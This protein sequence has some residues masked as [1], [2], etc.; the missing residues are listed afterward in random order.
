MEDLIVDPN[1]ATP[2]EIALAR[3]KAGKEFQ[4]ILFLS[5][6]NTKEYGSLLIDL[7][8]CFAG[9][10]DLYR[11]T[12]NEAYDRIVNYINLLKGHTTIMSQESGMAEDDCRPHGDDHNRRPTDASPLQTGCGGHG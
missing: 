10:G 5:K 12:L 9:N 3:E 6:A 4:A 1:T 8:N 7:H 2:D 11:E